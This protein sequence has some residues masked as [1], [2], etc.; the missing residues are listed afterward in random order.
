MIDLVQ[1]ATKISSMGMIVSVNINFW[2]GILSPRQEWDNIKI[3]LLSNEI[4]GSFRELEKKI[5]RNLNSYSIPCYDGLFVPSHV[6]N[7]WLLNHNELCERFYKARSIVLSMRESICDSARS[8]A[9]IKYTETW[10]KEHFLDNVPP[11]SGGLYASNLAVSLVPTK[12]QFYDLYKVERLFNQPSFAF[13]QSD[14]RCSFVDDNERKILAWKLIDDLIVGNAKRLLNC[15]EK[16]I[17]CKDVTTKIKLAFDGTKLFLNTDVLGENVLKNKVK[18]LY[19]FIHFETFE[20]VDKHKFSVLVEDINVL[21]KQFSSVSG[22]M[23]Y[24]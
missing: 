19:D 17:K 21:A 6:L 7:E 10:K 16:C 5:L 11:P 15:I 20:T 1:K 4:V 23:E 8:A 18:E 22:I 24:L 14:S 3:Q 12:E 9:L 2:S 13:I